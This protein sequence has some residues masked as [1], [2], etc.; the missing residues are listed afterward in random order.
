MRAVAAPAWITARHLERIAALGFSDRS[1][2]EYYECRLAAAN[3]R[4]D[5]LVALTRSRAR[6]AH[7]QL[8][9]LVARRAPGERTSW[10]PLLALFDSWADGHSVISRQVPTIWL[11]F[12]DTPSPSSSSG[13]ASGSRLY[14][15]PP[16]VSVCLVPAY[17]TDQPLDQAN[18]HRGLGLARDCLALI[19]PARCNEVEPMLSDCFA[20]LPVGARWIHLSVMLGRS[21]RAVKLY[22]SLPRGLLSSFLRDVEFSGDLDAISGLLEREYGRD[23]AGD[24]LLVD[25]NLDNYRDARRCT[26]GLALGQQ[27]VARGPDR[28]PRRTHAL[29][30]WVEAGHG[31]PARAASAQAWLAEPGRFLD[32]KL[33]WSAEAPLLAKVYLG[34]HA[35][36]ESSSARASRTSGGS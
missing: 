31:A 19:E 14:D 30:R 12:D 13:S 18:A 9:E 2:A 24:E 20:A 32:L 26:L 28:D 27:H 25:L 33:V 8:L 4:V 5:Y 11:E 34:S 7:Q 22:G 10:S 6:D 17:R 16:S 3:P 23:L 36:V 1:E 29:A 15:T 35:R 21:P